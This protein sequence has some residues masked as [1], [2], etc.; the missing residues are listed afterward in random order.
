MPSR[1]K[2]IPAIGIFLFFLSTVAFYILQ[3]LD[4]M[5]FLVQGDHGKD[6]YAFWRTSQG[7]IPYRDYW[8]VYGPLMPYY[9]GLLFKILGT[10]IFIVLLGQQIWVAGSAV[11]IYAIIKRYFH[12][13]WA[14]NAGLWFIVFRM[15]FT[16]TFNHDACVFFILICLYAL[17]SC[18]LHQRNSYIFTICACV[19]VISLIKINFGLAVGGFAFIWP[20]IS[21]RLYKPW[22]SPSK[23]LLRMG[24]CLASILILLVYAYHMAGLKLYQLKQCLPYFGS[25]EP[26]QNNPIISFFVLFKVTSYYLFSTHPI[27]ALIV[28][29]FIV[30]GSGAGIISAFIGS[31]ADERARQIRLLIVLLSGFLILLWN[32][33]FISGAI[34][35]AYW[36][37]SVI[38]L[39]LF[40][41]LAWFCKKY[42]KPLELSASILIL[43]YVMFSFANSVNAN[44]L[45][46]SR[47]S[48]LMASR[49][50]VFVG[51]DK[52]WIETMQSTLGYLRENLN[53][54]ETFLALP[55]EPLFYYMMD[56][57]SPSWLL[58]FFD[59]I[60][61]PEE[62]QE[63]IIQRL[64]TN[65][66]RFIVISNKSKSKG[67]G[68]GEFGVTHNKLLNAYISQQY[69]PVAQFGD[70][71]NPE[72]WFSP[73]GTKILER[74]H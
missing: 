57:K 18:A 68:M 66:A 33:F 72:G 39:I 15:P 46:K 71:V 8:W 45:N 47:Y 30:I 25:Y 27:W 41:G 73:V 40:V 21:S 23:R 53:A 62:Q 61:V 52:E 34:Y 49:G 13:L 54:G 48:Y 10:N 19:F 4:I 38:F 29:M 9:Y 42:G 2:N 17:F 44:N 3:N 74:I 24:L 7:E 31:D 12:P 32:E 37:F 11:I 51:N 5:P 14:A 20:V 36:G 16:H 43:S 56:I 67:K 6:L 28:L 70:W 58:A 64:K 63:E 59:H 22:P 60:N 26:N 65:G 55:Y 50:K 69:K 35:R 1:Q